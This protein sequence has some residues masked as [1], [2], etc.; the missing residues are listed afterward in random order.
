MFED[1]VDVVAS[2]IEQMKVLA[3]RG[4]VDLFLGIGLQVEQVEPLQAYRR[5]VDGIGNGGFGRD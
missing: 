5:I 1:T 2:D 4:G 3:R